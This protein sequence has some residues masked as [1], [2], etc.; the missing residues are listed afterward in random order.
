MKILITG[1]SGL[2]GKSL[3]E[4]KPDDVSLVLTWF[5]NIYGVASGFDTW[6]KLDVRSQAD[7]YEVFQ[8]VQPDAVIHC[9]AIGSVDYAADHYDEVAGVNI[10][11]TKNV[12]NAANGFDATVIY[13]STNA[14]YSGNLPPYSEIS[15]LE[16]VNDYGL[17]KMQ[18]ERYVRD[19]AKS[20]LIIRPFLLYG[21]PYQGAR[22]NWA[23]AI[24]NKLRDGKG[25]FKMVNDCVW[26][27]TYA[28]DCAAAIWKLLFQIQDSNE[29]FNV[30]SP[31]RSTLYEF[32][33][34]GCEVFGLDQNLISPVG[35]DYFP[36][37]AQRPV[38]T[39]Y[40]LDKLTAAGIILADIKTGL[41][42]MRKDEK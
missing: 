38:D 30:A 11:G 31:E 40:D 16:P 13:I 18:A 36:S 39:S 4:T 20:W 3:L 6:Y 28:P 41:K 8:M 34:K 21:W 7:V 12:V 17:I 33:L 23:N 32:G 2:L 42:R 5:K 25:G 9:A 22:N 29:I 35:S 1:G 26:M 15:P 27:P 19:I 14:V 10:A 24:I 37:I